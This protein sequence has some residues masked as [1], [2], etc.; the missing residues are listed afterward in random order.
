MQSAGVFNSTLTYLKALNHIG[1]VL[2]MATVDLA[3]LC[4]VVFT[5]YMMRVSALEI[6]PASKLSLYF[7]APVLSVTFMYLAGIYRHV[8]RNFSTQN[9]IRLL[10]S[11]LSVPVLWALILFGNGTVGF[12]RS[13]VL[14]YLI[15]SI[16]ALVMV[17]RLAAHVFS[18]QSVA[19]PHRERIPVLI[20]GAGKEGAMLVDALNRQG[21]Y[22]PVAFLDTD[23]T[24]VGRTANGLKIKS[25]EEL[26]KVVAKYAPQEV[27]I[28]KSKQ[29]RSSR[30]ALV[31]MFIERGLKIK[32]VPAIDDIVD[33]TIDVHSLRPIK[34]EDLL[35]R[36]PVPPVKTLMDFAVKDRSVLVTG[37]GGSI[38][39]ELVR[40]VSGFNPARVVLLDNN[41]FALFEIHREM[42]L[43]FAALSSPPQ[44]VAVL[45]TVM[46]KIAIEKIMSDNRIEVVFHA[47]AYKHVR[48]VQENSISGIRNN[49]L[50]TQVVAQAAIR[51][52]VKLFVL[53]STDKA[54]RPTSVMG[55][56]KRV[57][58]M[59]VQSLSRRASKNQ[60]FSMVR[61]GNVLGSTGSVVPLFQQQISTGGPVKVTHPEVTRYFM[62][63]PEAAQLVIQAAAMAERGE[64]LVL[65]MG[66]PVKIADLAKTMIDLAGL[67]VKSDQNPEGEIAIEFVGLRDGEKLFEE[68]QIGSNVSSTAHS[69]IMRSDE[70]YMPWQE[71]QTEL[72][73]LNQY[74]ASDDKR[75]ANDHLMRLAH[76]GSSSK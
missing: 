62:L 14:I 31:E 69:R 58:E 42:E 75:K 61:F 11:Q 71:L 41:E 53:I 18:D 45:A 13:V 55:A 12:A 23:Y 22:R 64:V 40:Q 35:G 15:L 65:D 28:A 32:T 9:E 20:Y 51:Q 4:V 7:V 8:S 47:A 38:G 37:A 6:P 54:V 60:I 59:I 43:R 24:L 63:I 16:L 17:R 70:Y 48:M 74:L 34:L 49:V 25:I 33:G 73:L 3:V 1:K 2:I 26:D 29:N 52:K 44:L 21:R 56:S 19:I 57:A 39:S 5:S 50:G 27:M 72:G 66:E 76:L 30:R 46:D 10:I 68:L 67:S 36:D